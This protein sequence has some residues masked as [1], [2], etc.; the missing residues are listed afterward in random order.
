M[1]IVIAT[2]SILFAA[3]VVTVS[4][5]NPDRVTVRLW[6][7]APQYVYPDTPVSWVIFFSA[8]AGFVFTGIIAVLE[9]SKT[10][11][12]NAR[13]RAQIRRLQQEIETLRRPSL[14]LTLSPPRDLGP[15]PPEAGVD[16][17]VEIV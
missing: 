15:A 1:R 5:V 11:L 2:L 7:D 4:V 14:D 3:C 9:G 16:E 12:S 10:R 6:P 13:L 8:F 17:E